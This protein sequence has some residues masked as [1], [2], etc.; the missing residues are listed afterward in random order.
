MIG[1]VLLSVVTLGCGGGDSG[2]APHG[3]QLLVRPQF[4][5]QPQRFRH[6]LKL[7]TVL[8]LNSMS[9]SL[10]LLICLPIFRFQSNLWT[11]LQGTLPLH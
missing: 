5:M 4:R 1:V 9:M 11:G 8:R 10:S 2:V 6:E 7:K 3:Q